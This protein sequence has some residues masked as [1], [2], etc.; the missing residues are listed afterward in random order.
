MTTATKLSVGDVVSNGVS[1]GLKNFVPLLITG[2][3]YV[4][5]IWIPYLNLGTTIGLWDLVAKLGRGESVN[6]TD[7]F[8]EKYRSRIGDFF[9]LL[10]FLAAGM[11]AGFVVPGAGTVIQMAWMLALPLFV[12]KGTDPLESITMSNKLM[13]GNKLTVF[14]A[15]IVLGVAMA[16][17]AA[18][19][20]FIG[21]QI[22]ELLGVLFLMVIYALIL[23]VYLGVVSYVYARL[24]SGREA[25]AVAE[26]VV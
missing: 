13:H 7:I 2:I 9:L 20:M 25:E 1:I 15:F 16:I 11:I 6:P 8:D 19:L 26:P 10:A 5:T 12:D 18:I 22:H 4:V 17:G 3:L 14:L 23:P 21:A 24:G